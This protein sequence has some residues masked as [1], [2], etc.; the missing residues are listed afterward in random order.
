[1]KRIITIGI[2][3]CIFLGNLSII[4]AE[5]DKTQQVETDDSLGTVGG[6]LSTAIQSTKTLFSERK[7]LTPNTGH[8]FAA[9]RAN[10]LN[11]VL[12]GKNSIVV[13]DD[14]SKN[15][16]DIKILNRNGTAIY[17]QDK[18]CKTATRTVNAAFDEETGLYRY[19]VNDNPMQLEVP[20]DQ[21][22]QAVEVMGKKI[23]DGKVPGVTDLD[24]ASSLVKKGSV[25][26]K[27]AVNITKAGN[28]DSL[29]Y[30]SK[31]GAIVAN[32]AMGISFT[33]D[34]AVRMIQGEKVDIALKKSVANSLQV[35]GTTFLIYVL[36]SQLT[37]TGAAK[38]F[39]PTATSISKVLGDN[40]S[41]T[42]V[43]MFAPGSSVTENTVTSILKNQMLVTTATSA[44][45][46]VPDIIDLFKG[47]ISP[48]QLATNLAVAVAGTAGATV[49]TIAGGSL[50]S[51]IVPGVGTTIGGILGGTAG[52]IAASWGASTL[53]STVFEN[54]AENM[55]NILIEECETIANEYVM[56]EDEANNMISNLN[57]SLD[58][59][60]LK[61]MFEENNR[62][63]FAIDLITTIAEKIVK[64]RERIEMPSEAT[65]RDN[66]LIQ[67]N[68]V[69]YIH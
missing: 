38:V 45:L 5:D 50:G 37:K 15:G 60:I 62:E 16:A 18:Y 59:D 48:Q 3:T 25:T 67:V 39:T 27:Q 9:E 47:R 34:I 69:V 51:M 65:I 57:D 26:Y 36:S 63:A 42:M 7:F 12:S 10:N 17:I 43:T 33:L 1:M 54:D 58:N 31:N 30:D 61:D 55:Y 32:A 29:V 64:N 6:Y 49:G 53:L 13:G 23:K 19:Y 44:V 21:Y 4:N 24:Q 8:G 41:N 2:A 52:G 14:N 22:D 56:T 66:L 28:I 68:D 11:N 40:V 46:T 20:K 35:G